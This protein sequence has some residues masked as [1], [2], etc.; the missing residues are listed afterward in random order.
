MTKIASNTRMQ[1]TY[2]IQFTLEINLE[3]TIR[4]LASGDG[5]KGVTTCSISTFLINTCE[6][7]YEM[8]EE[9]IRVSDKHFLRI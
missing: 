8:L 9:Y 5:F 1:D 2:M 6:A 3:I 4:Y 7:S